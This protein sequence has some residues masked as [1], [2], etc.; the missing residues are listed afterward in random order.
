MYVIG[1]LNLPELNSTQWSSGIGSSPLSQSFLDMFNNMCFEQCI[2]QATH[3]HGKI[4][5]ILLTNSPQSLARISVGDENS[6]C[7]SDHYPVFYDIKGL[8]FF[9]FL[10]SIIFLFFS[11]LVLG[12]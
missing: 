2:E 4:L 5:D 9:F 7:F 11:L 6:V 10:N 1:D 8:F 12:L 3:R